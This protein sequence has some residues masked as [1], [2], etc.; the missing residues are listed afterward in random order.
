M[1]RR[2]RLFHRDGRNN[3]HRP[4]HLNVGWSHGTPADEEPEPGEEQHDPEQHTLSF[5]HVMRDTL[6]G[7]PVGKVC[8]WH[9]ERPSLCVTTLIGRSGHTDNHGSHN[10]GWYVLGIAGVCLSELVPFEKFA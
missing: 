1:P 6:A 7:R 3:H 4:G 5:A 10:L 8:V 2:Q 9:S